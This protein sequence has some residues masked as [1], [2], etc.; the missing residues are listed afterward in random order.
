MTITA[1]VTKRIIKHLLKGEDYRVEVIALI[2]ATFLQFAID[3]FKKI[4]DAKLRNENITV[5]WYKQTFLVI[6]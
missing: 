5:D 6:K 3:F 1:E 4:V 2:N